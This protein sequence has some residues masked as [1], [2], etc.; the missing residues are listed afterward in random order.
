M[1]LI[2]FYFLSMFL[3]FS[4]SGE[5][6]SDQEAFENEEP[7]FVSETVLVDTTYPNLNEA[8]ISVM[9]KLKMCT[10][11]DTSKLA[12]CSNQYFR[13]F[14]HKPKHDWSEGFIVEMV[15]GL[16]GAPVNQI[17]VIE[18][19]KGGYQIANQYLGR[20]IELRST[21]NGYNDLLIG[22]EDP[23]IGLIAIRHEWVGNKYE[24]KDVEEIN[25]HFVK[26]E[27]KDSINNIFLPAFSAGF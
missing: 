17:V 2:P 4:C 3:I 24:L 14:D 15:P 9:E 16:Y 20:M 11:S 18:E 22:Y 5:G 26:P 19:Q 23:D 1:R 8:C 12:P 6:S 21:K 7:P 27:M 10:T 25:N 13:V